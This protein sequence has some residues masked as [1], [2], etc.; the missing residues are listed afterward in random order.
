MA[1]IKLN[2]NFMVEVNAF[3]ASGEALDQESGS[4]VSTDYLSL[5]TVDAYQE[6]LHRIWTLMIKFRLLTQKDAKDMDALATSLRT[7]DER[8]C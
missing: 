2:D 3:R 1:E 7:T 6:R 4:S 8:G 5:P